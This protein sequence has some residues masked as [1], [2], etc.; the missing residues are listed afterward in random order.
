MS[1]RQ[2]IGTAHAVLWFDTTRPR[3]HCADAVS[4][5]GV[6]TMAGQDAF[7]PKPITASRGSYRTHPRATTN[8]LSGARSTS[9]WV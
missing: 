7:V 6:N 4:P 9:A 3:V 8:R 1:S 5:S 2:P